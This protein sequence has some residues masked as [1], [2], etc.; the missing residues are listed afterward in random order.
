MQYRSKR[1]RVGCAGQSRNNR[2]R[3]LTLTSRDTRFKRQWVSDAPRRQPR[4]AGE[5]ALATR[6]VAGRDSMHLSL[7]FFDSFD[8]RLH[9]AGL[10]LLQVATPQ[11]RFCA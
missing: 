5:D 7:A 2:S 9:A 6:A 8:W 4:A 1:A 3:Q 10:R 11:A